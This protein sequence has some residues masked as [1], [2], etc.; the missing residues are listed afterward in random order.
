MRIPHRLGGWEFAA[1]LAEELG[2]DAW[3]ER[4]FDRNI[5]YSTLVHLTGPIADPAGLVDWVA[6]R[7]DLALD[8]ITV[9][10]SDLVRFRFG[11]RRPI[12]QTL[13]R[14][15]PYPNSLANPDTA[16]ARV[17]SMSVMTSGQRCSASSV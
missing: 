13:S 5:W 11:G 9:R 17:R 6:S 12:C 4:D 14:A 3:F 1:R 8:A 16:A 7:R 10:A 15:V 2:A